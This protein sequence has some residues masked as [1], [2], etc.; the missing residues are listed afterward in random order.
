M[1]SK[2][3]VVVRPD[4]NPKQIGAALPK[5][6]DGETTIRGIYKFDDGKLHVAFALKREGDRPATFD[7]V[8]GDKPPLVM[9]LKKAK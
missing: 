8:G 1:P 6:P 3:S 2:F 9:V 7:A 5:G 4:E